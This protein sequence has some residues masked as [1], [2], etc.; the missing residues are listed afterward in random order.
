MKR[1]ASEKYA[2]NEQ[3]VADLIANAEWL[4]DRLA[5]KLMVYLG[6]R[7]SEVAH[8]RRDWIE[9]G[10]LCIPASQPCDCANCKGTWHAKSKASIRT[11]PIPEL[12]AN[13]LYTFLQQSPEGFHITRVTLWWKIKKIAKKAG[14][15]VKGMSKETISPHILRATAATRLAAGGMSAVGLCYFCGWSSLKMGQHYINITMAKRDA[16]RQFKEIMG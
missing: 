16:Y 6:M 7:V 9:G 13:D 14:I 15:R 10:E 8:L 4:E 2:L 12:I 11:L 3:Q 1:G 5:I